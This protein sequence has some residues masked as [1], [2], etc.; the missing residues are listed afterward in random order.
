MIPGLG[1]VRRLGVGI[2]RRLVVSALIL[3]GLFALGNVV[4][5]RIA[6]DKLAGVVRS[7]FDLDEEPSVE[8]SAFPIILKVISGS[9]PKV[10]LHAN[11]A[12]V[13]DLTLRQVAIVLEDVRIDGGLLTGGKLAVRI[14]SGSVTAEAD[15]EA[16]GRFFQERKE[17]VAI[18]FYEGG[19]DVRATR[20]IAGKRRR[21]TAS[22]TIRLTKGAL[23]FVPKKIRVDGE[24]P[25][26]ALQR[27]ARREVTIKV[28][29][30]KLPG[31]F[32]PTAVSPHEGY[33]RIEAA[34]EDERLAL[35]G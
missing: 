22:G 2:L 29:L 1:I 30:P 3:A 16:A 10:S 25:S 20:R 13:Q 7:T 24:K 23:A 21:I 34:L 19:A 12:T 27:E 33:V 31:G 26:G 6:E 4:V 35:G 18:S 28:K 9:L 8:I 14:G 32:A 5:E 17:R 15:D 11:G